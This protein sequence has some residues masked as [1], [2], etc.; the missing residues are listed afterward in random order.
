M[1]NYSG[2]IIEAQVD[3]LTVSAHGEDQAR[4]L[5]DL[6]MGLSKE[7]ERK[8]NE[9]HPFRLMGYEGVACGPIQYGQRDDKATILRLSGES[10][11]DVL[12]VAMS[13][14][15][16][17]S[18][19]DLAVTWRCEPPDPMLGR[20]AYTMADLHRQTHP[21]AALP[22]FTGDAAGG[23]T[24]YV[25]KRGGN[26]MLRI[27][28]K[29]AEA[30]AQDDDDGAERYR[31][32]WR[33]ELEAGHQLAQR[34][35]EIVLVEPD[36][37]RFV[38]DYVY[39]HA[40]RHGIPPAFPRAGGQA[41]IPG[42]RRRSDDDRSLQHIR[43]SVRPTAERLRRHG[44]DDDLREA[45]GF[46]QGAS[47]LRELQTILMRRYGSVADGGTKEGRENG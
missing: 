31:A 15:D 36:R 8:G 25:G 21:Q 39:A 13:V 22:W 29:G 3:Y 42:F 10:A 11:N 23:F 24:C 1:S 40:E 28:N 5:L 4:N 7:S 17:V 2:T 44:R 43:K 34:L 41:L 38:Q 18:R 47:L 27:Y 37:A 45:L 30:V 16:R 12:D 20:N 35:A 33:Y 26:S 46:D 19:I 9:P 6:G 14:A 32:C